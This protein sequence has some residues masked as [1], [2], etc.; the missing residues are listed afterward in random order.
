MIKVRLAGPD[1][2]IDVLDWR[3]DS[4]TRIMSW[5]DDI[6]DKKTHIEWFNASIENRKRIL[7]IAELK[8]MKV[9]MIRFDLLPKI[10]KVWRVSIIVAPESRNQGLGANLLTQA[11]V[12]FHSKFPGASVLA[13]VKASNTASHS[14]FERVGFSKIE[15]SEEKNVYLLEF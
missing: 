5:N 7:L 4:Q 13:E 10:V 11:I 6:I 15:F 12:Y 8:E 9:G 1:D 3:N 14:I 2:A